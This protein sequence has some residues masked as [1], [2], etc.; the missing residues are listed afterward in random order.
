M[1]P[2]GIITMNPEIIRKIKLLQDYFNDLAPYVAMG[3]GEILENKEKLAAMERYFL[4]MADE[5]FDVNAALAYQ[6]GNKIPESNKSTFFELADLKI[7]DRDFAEKI[8]DSAKTRNQLTHDYDKVQDRIMVDDMKK[9][10]EMYKEYLKILI[11]KF[12]TKEL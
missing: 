12:V 3:T 10:V 9:F 4:L 1:G 6:L 5:A 2:N 7:L 11:E 8:A